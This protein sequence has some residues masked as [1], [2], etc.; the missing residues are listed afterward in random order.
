MLSIPRNQTDKQR[1]IKNNSP[2]DVPAML[3]L[4]RYTDPSKKEVNP[5]TKYSLVGLCGQCSS[6]SSSC[7]SAYIFC[8]GVWYECTDETIKPINQEMMLT[9]IKNSVSVALYKKNSLLTAGLL[10][11]TNFMHKENIQPRIVVA[12]FATLEKYSKNLTELAREKRLDPLIG[13]TNELQQVIEILLRRTK[14]NPILV[15]LPGVGKTALA[16]GIAQLIVEQHVPQSMWN[17]E[18]FSLDLL[19]AYM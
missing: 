8:E 17:K 6:S 19:D 3:D 4:K 9:T 18:V 1:I 12:R 15:G 14:N 11:P 5:Q 2:L 7:L 10:H 16:E 13:R